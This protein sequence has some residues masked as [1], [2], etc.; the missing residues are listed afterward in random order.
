[1][2]LNWE[3]AE[4]LHEK[5]LQK[6]N[7]Y[8][9][10]KLK[11]LIR[12]YEEAKKAILARLAQIDI[13]HWDRAR[14]ERLLA[15]IDRDLLVLDRYGL[16]ALRGKG[17]VAIAEQIVALADTWVEQTLG[18]KV[19]GTFAMIHR[20]ALAFLQDYELG[21]IKNVNQELRN[22]I[23]NQLTQAFIQGESIPQMVKRLT[24]GT[25]LQRGVFQKIETRAEVIARTETIRAF[26]QGA[27]EQYRSYGVKRVIWLTAQ[28]ERTCPVCRPLHKK[29]FPIDRIPF[30]GPP[31]HP[32]C[33]CAVVA[34]IV[35]DEEEAKRANEEAIKN[36]W[37]QVKR[38]NDMRR[39]S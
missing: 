35:T 28:D 3:D 4:R 1:M 8:E 25:A 6:L 24:S 18:V 26:N 23:R 10:Q 37:E 15:E 19:I 31:A 32:R 20:S 14:L 33:R 7:H 13:E 11:N 27:L 34:H 12:G 38:I 9:R 21:L 39:K 22:Q 29:V 30:G 5:I 16:D 17:D 36:Y 2:A